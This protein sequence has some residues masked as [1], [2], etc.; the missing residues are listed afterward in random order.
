MTEQN[1]SKELIMDEY[2]TARKQGLNEEQAFHYVLFMLEFKPSMFKVRDHYADEI[3]SRF[4][5]GSMIAYAD[6]QCRQILV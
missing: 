6:W 5:N 3:I 4:K 1:V 2:Y